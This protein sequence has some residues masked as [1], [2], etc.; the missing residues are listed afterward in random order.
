MVLAIGLACSKGFVA[1]V[2][3]ARELPVIGAEARAAG[4][5]AE[6]AAAA[7]ADASQAAA[8]VEQY[9]ASG[10]SGEMPGGRPDDDSERRVEKPMMPPV[11]SARLENGRPSARHAFALPPEL[12]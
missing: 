5:E 1:L 8:R 7:D 3:L 9:D 12:Q 2:D 6:A 4:T 10:Q 11:M